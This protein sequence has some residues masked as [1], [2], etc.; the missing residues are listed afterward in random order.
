[1][2]DMTK[3]P[4]RKS[5]VIPLNMCSVKDNRLKL[6]LGSNHTVVELSPKRSVT[7][8]DV[9]AYAG[10]RDIDIQN[11]FV[12]LGISKTAI[13]AVYFEN[14]H[15]MPKSYRFNFTPNKLYLLGNLSGFG[16]NKGATQTLF[17]EQPAT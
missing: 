10:G 17:V 9:Q 14:I 15:A 2:S 13:Q 11:A 8:V 4:T 3:L 7:Q 16:V 12:L 1:M 5:L 6:L